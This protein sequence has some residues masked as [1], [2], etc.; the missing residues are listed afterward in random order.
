MDMSTIGRD[1]FVRRSFPMRHHTLGIAK[2][3]LSQVKHAAGGV[4]NKLPGGFISQAQEHPVFV[5]AAVTGATYVLVHL[6]R[7]IDRNP[8]STS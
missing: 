6:S 7:Q 5:A 1:A 2:D 3:D 4:L 8:V